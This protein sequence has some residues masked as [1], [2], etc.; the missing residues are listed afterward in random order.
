MDRELICP[1][2]RST[3]PFA[4]GLVAQG[5]SGGQQAA[6][7]VRWEVEK[8]LRAFDVELDE[9][10][11]ETN[12]PAEVICHVFV[13]KAALVNSLCKE[14]VISS[15]ATWDEFALA[16][17]SASTCHLVDIG[18]PFDRAEAAWTAERCARAR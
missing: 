4:D 6:V 18:K 17:N 15:G 7:Q 10:D 5:Q 13:N 2:C 9:Q 8:D 12:E 16:F 14:R 3:A 1:H 11:V